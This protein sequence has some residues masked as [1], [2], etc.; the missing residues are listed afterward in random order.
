MLMSLVLSLN[1]NHAN[2]P[3]ANVSKNVR[4]DFIAAVLIATLGVKSRDA[5]FAILTD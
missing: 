4:E 5:V 1:G 3:R 2:H